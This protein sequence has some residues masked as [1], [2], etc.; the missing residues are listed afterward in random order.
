MSVA[1]F[2]KHPFASLL[3]PESRWRSQALLDIVR[4]CR[5]PLTFVKSGNSTGVLPPATDF[6][7]KM[8]LLVTFL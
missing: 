5:L 7:G 6:S 8:A 1:P 4:F 3:E 2:R